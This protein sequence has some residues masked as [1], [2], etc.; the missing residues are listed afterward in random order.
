VHLG[1][2]GCFRVVCYQSAGHNCE[3]ALDV[4]RQRW[5]STHALPAGI[6]AFELFSSAGQVHGAQVHGLQAQMPFPQRQDP[7]MQLH[8]FCFFDV[9]IDS[10]LLS[11]VLTH[12]DGE[13]YSSNFATPEIFAENGNADRLERAQ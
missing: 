6:Y 5:G 11:I 7:G 3:H 10:F 8:P 12:L 13:S 2:M 9:S 1:E 4:G